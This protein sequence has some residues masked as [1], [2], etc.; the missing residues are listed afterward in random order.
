MLGCEAADTGGVSEGGGASV[1]GEGGRVE[2]G[3]ENAAVS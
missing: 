1:V 2:A 3:L